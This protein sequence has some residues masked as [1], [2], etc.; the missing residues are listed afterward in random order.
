MATVEAIIRQELR[1]KI[2]QE[3]RQSPLSVSCGG[4][5]GELLRGGIQRGQVGV[6]AGGR[7]TEVGRL[8]GGSVGTGGVH[9]WSG[10]NRAGRQGAGM[11]GACGIWQASP[12]A[13][14]S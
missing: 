14:G 10:G 4:R 13:S 12:I 2:R 11:V 7:R 9:V 8:G 5:V 6:G 1:Q 3:L